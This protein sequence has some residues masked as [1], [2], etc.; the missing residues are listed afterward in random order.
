MT[1]LPAAEDLLLAELEVTTPSGSATYTLPL[2][3]AWEGERHGPFASNLAIARVRRVRHVGLLTDGFALAPFARSVLTGMAEGAVV[4]TEGG[5]LHFAKT[6]RFD[7][8]P[9][10]E[11]EWLAAEQSNSTVTPGIHPDAEMVGYLADNGFANVPPVL[12]TVTRVADGEETLLMIAQAFVYNQGDGWQWTLGA[13]ERLSTDMDWSFTNYENFASNLGRRLAEMHAV[14]ALPTDDP[15]FAPE[16]L[17]AADASALADRITAELDKALSRLRAAQLDGKAAEQASWLVAE[18]DAIAA[19]IAEV[20]MQAEG[21]SRTRIHGDLHLGQVLV[22]GSDVM[23]IDF[24]G[25][26]TRPLADRR[27]K[28]LPLRDVAGMIRSFDYAGAVAEQ[29]RPAGAESWAERAEE[30]AEMFRVRAIS[31]FLEGYHG[32][33]SVDPLLLLFILEKA[34]Y[35]VSYEVAN[36]P[37]WIGVP[38]RGLARAGRRLLTG[39][40]A[41]PGDL[42]GDDT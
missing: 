30:G 23:I 40:T 38:V 2:G 21:R 35:E 13:L 24:E 34:A 11:P 3:I 22:T 7:I 42:I 33:A 8:D 26:P 1:E 17:S 28:D 27:A 4:P 16:R 6:S 25:E 37:D 39:D 31:A 15:S 10:A 20:A 41:P 14:L 9:A 5:A 19:R 29:S 18:R 36:R 12:G 32:K